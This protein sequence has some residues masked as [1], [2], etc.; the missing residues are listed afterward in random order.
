M[1]LLN[2]LGPVRRSAVLS[3]RPVTMSARGYA[4]KPDGEFS[5]QYNRGNPSG[6]AKKEQVSDCVDHVKKRVL[7]S[8]SH[9]ANENQ[10]VQQ[11]EAEKLKNRE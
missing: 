3:L 1:S 10:Y 6:F 5:A 8:Q 4:D 7:T 9:Q 2:T 11:Q